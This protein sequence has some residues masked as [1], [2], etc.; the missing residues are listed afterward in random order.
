MSLYLIVT[1]FTMALNGCFLM[2]QLQWHS[3]LQ[4]ALCNGQNLLSE[5]TETVGC[6]LSTNTYARS[7]TIGYKLYNTLSLWIMLKCMLWIHLFMVYAMLELE[8]ELKYQIRQINQEIHLAA[9]LKY[10][11]RK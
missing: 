6:G 1:R 5:T 3:T 4:Q 10:G 2:Q 8:I 7:A 9:K 11:R